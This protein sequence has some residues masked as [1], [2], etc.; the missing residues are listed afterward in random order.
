MCQKCGA[1]SRNGKLVIVDNCQAVLC[2]SCKT[3]FDKIKD[4][5]NIPVHEQFEAFQ[6]FCN[7]DISVKF[8]NTEE[9][10]YGESHCE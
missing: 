4:F 3:D 5:Y 8:V 6:M 1:R 7:R 10:E 2:G 9:L